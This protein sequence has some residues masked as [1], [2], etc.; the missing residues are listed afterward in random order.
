VARGALLL[1]SLLLVGLVGCATAAED[2]PNANPRPQR[3][4]SG[5]VD[6]SSLDDDADLPTD[7]GTDGTVSPDAKADGATDTGPKPDGAT[8][9]GPKPDGGKVPKCGDGIIDPGELCDDGANADGDGCSADCKSVECFGTRTWEDPVT[10]HCYWRSTDVV[11]RNTAAT[12][13]VEWGGY[14]ARFETAAERFGPFPTL[15]DGVGGRIWIGVQ[16]VDGVWTWDDGK[17]ATPSELPWGSGEP[18][19]DGPCAEWRKN[20]NDYNDLGCGNDRDFI[21]ERAPKGK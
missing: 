6:T 18:S 16:R 9:T 7:A 1:P 3:R 2:E 10:H 13:C 12:R 15:L 4:D 21:C 5:T 8:D 17:V 14:L 11:G 20:G 19:G